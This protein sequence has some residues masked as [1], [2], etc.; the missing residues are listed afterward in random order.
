MYIRSSHTLTLLLI[1]APALMRMSLSD[2]IKSCFTPQRQE[3]EKQGEARSLA[4][5]SSVGYGKASAEREQ[6][7]RMAIV[8]HSA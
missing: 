7:E 6:R 5:A 1:K 3:S 4:D 2:K 8:C